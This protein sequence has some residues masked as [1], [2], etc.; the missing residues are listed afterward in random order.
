MTWTQVGPA[1]PP[2]PEARSIADH[3]QAGVGSAF[4]ARAW[5]VGPEP[6]VTCH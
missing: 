6:I 5:S 3:L 4:A 2:R 1:G